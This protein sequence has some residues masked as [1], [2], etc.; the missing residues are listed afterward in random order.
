[1]AVIKESRVLP[2]PALLTRQAVAGKNKS[3][4]NK[5]TNENRWLAEYAPLRVLM[6]SGV[7]VVGAFVVNLYLVCQ[8]SSLGVTLSVDSNANHLV[9]VDVQNPQSNGLAVGDVIT[10]FI[11]EQGVTIP[12]TRN[13]L[14]KIPVDEASTFAEFNRM[15]SEQ[16]LL[17][18]LYTQPQSSA[19]LEDGK[20][21]PLTLVTP[22]PLGYLPLQYWLVNL[23]GAIVLL[24]GVGLW[25]IRRGEVATRLLALSGVGY[26]LSAYFGSMFL[27][28]ELAMPVNW[29]HIIG[30]GNSLGCM[31][32]AYS[33]LGLL[34]YYP[35]RLGTSKMAVW[36][37]AA[38]GISLTNEVLQIVDLP[39]HTFDLQYLFVFFLGLGFAFS[40]WRRA[41]KNPVARAALLWFLLSILL[42]TGLIVALYFLPLILKS[43]PL[44]TPAVTYYLVLML[45]IGLALGVFRF[46]LFRLEKW[47]LKA[48]VCYFSGILVLVV[49]VAIAY[50]LNL[51]LLEGLSL[52]L[53]S[54]VWF[55]FP[56]RQW[57]WERFIVPPRQRLEHFLPQ[58]ITSFYSAVSAEQFDAKWCV[59]L[60][61]MFESLHAGRTQL[62]C[63]QSQLL[64]NGLTLRVPAISKG[65]TVVLTGRNQSTRLFSPEDMQTADSLF[66]IA[67]KMATIR[68]AHDQGVSEERE[69]IKRDLHDDV[70]AKLLTLMNR[71]VTP[72]DQEVARSALCSL[73]DT[74]YSLEEKTSFSVEDALADIRAE[75]GER[76][77][78]AGISLEWIQ[79]AKK[80]SGTLA[81]LQ[82][83]NV[84]RIIREAISNVVVHAY[85]RQVVVRI[86]VVN[87]NLSITVT[88]NGLSSDVSQWVLGVGTKSIMRRAEELGGSA[89]WYANEAGLSGGSGVTFELIIPIKMEKT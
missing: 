25:S 72:S 70:G 28:R 35:K 36:I 52:V 64:D 22:I 50:A 2:A 15:L 10:A 48:W 24:V 26:W 18:R 69:R 27:F 12:L 6:V 76:L 88:D 39:L 1:M 59:F 34:W 55:Y 46:Q 84:V 41:R 17:Y 82:S 23:L 89:R 57:C 49:D 60:A 53:L 7:F 87:A 31:L 33:M 80:I 16:G 32:L 43:K 83:I 62:Y 3:N 66:S 74:I 61:S 77:E 85:A 75:A 78:F 37:F 73:R 42:S 21:V 40:Q 20:V 63:K 19:L 54:V 38:M 44:V 14:A 30:A 13:A 71:A 68:Q 29:L 67:N 5:A 8:L 81:Y 51:G 9:V 4:I 11:S 58:F 65:Q 79:R 45:Y 56:I 86:D 47:W